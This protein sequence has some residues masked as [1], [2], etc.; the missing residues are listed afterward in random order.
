MSIHARHVPLMLLLLTMLGACAMPVRQ[1]APALL[2]LLPPAALGTSHQS[3][4]IVHAAFGER[5]MSVQCILTVDARQ[6]T[7]IGLSP[8]GQRLFDI[9]YDGQTVAVE[10]SPLLPADLPV[11]RF[12][13]DLQLAYWP[14]PAWRAALA[15]SDWQV[16]EPVPGTRRLHHHQ[17]LIAEV[18]QPDD[19]PWQ[20]RLWLSNFEFD[21]SLS[22]DAEPLP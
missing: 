15:G 2:P 19:T 20:G 14:L 6:V 13:S 10:Q 3:R 1:D 21:Y 8:L 18:H 4:Q 17:R 5:E 7:V 11:Q 12:L 16:S 9:R 22:I